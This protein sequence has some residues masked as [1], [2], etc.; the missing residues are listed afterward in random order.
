MSCLNNVVPVTVQPFK[1]KH[2]GLLGIL[3]TQKGHNTFTEMS[4]TKTNSVIACTTVVYW[5]PECM[6]VLL[7]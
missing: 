5:P 2:N 6:H 4:N 1:L 7:N 3:K